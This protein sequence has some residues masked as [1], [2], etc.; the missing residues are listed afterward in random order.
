M[1]AHSSTSIIEEIHA[2]AHDPNA[3]L[4]TPTDPEDKEAK[5]AAIAKA[6][7]GGR[8]KALDKFA[9][10]APE[11]FKAFLE[12]KREG[13]QQLVDFYDDKAPVCLFPLYSSLA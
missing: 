5:A 12:K 10:E 7:L 6:F 2:S 8:Q 3:T 9:P 11:E 13:N 4:L 1:S